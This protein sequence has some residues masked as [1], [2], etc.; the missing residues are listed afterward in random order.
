MS[1]TT[2]EPKALR[3]LPK[4]RKYENRSDKELDAALEDAI[5]KAEEA[6]NDYLKNVLTNELGSHYYKRKSQN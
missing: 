6:G 5:K 2:T 3:D 4:D 1:R